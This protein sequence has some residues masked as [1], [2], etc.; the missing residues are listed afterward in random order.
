MGRWDRLTAARTPTSVILAALIL[1]ASVFAVLRLDAGFASPAPGSVISPT[2][3]RGVLATVW[4]KRER[5]RTNDY[6]AGLA[7]VDTG[8][9]L[10]RDTSVGAEAHDTG[11]WSQRVLRPIRDSAVFVPLQ[12]TYPASFLAAVQTTS[13]WSRSPTS[14]T[15]EGDEAALLVLTKTNRSAPWR[16]AMETGYKGSIMESDVGLDLGDLGAGNAYAAPAPQPAW[17]RPAN[18]IAMLTGYFQHFAEYGEAPP[19]SPFLP[20]YWTTG[21]GERISATGPNGQVNSKGFRN[22]VTYSSDS[23]GD[24]VYQFDVGG[25]N[26]TCGTVRGTETASGAGPG[27]G[28]NQPRDRDNWGGWLAPGAYSEITETLMHQVCLVIAPTSVGG[29]KAISGEGEESSLNATGVLLSES[30]SGEFE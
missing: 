24:G 21:L 26:V 13:Q 10:A 9:E 4:A 7:A 16:V 1:G 29:I 8:P 17:T 6:T 30:P 12:T 3:A 5:L 19:A 20:S 18:S 27:G 28:L 15:P 14:T 25:R 11:A 2:A 23:A 22:S